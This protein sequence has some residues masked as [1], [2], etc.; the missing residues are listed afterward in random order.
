MPLTSGQSAPDIEAPDQ[1]RVIHR[2]S[3]ERG[4]WVLL[5]FYPKDETPGCTKEACGFRD[6]YEDLKRNNVVIWGINADSIES[7]DSFR[8][9][10]QLPFPLLAD[11]DRR[12]I[13]AY[14]A[15]GPKGTLRV[16][17]LIDP[18]GQISRIYDEVDP[19]VHPQEVLEDVSALAA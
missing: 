3:D 1:D 12:I 10:F 18:E 9:H 7:H 14:G 16:S 15:E 5:Y 6:L 8:R 2:L 19:S 13:K 4:K 11:P 17:Y